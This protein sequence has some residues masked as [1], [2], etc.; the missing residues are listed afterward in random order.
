MTYDPKETEKKWQDFW[1]RE[2]IYRFDF[3]SQKEV[4]S[5][6]NPPRY[7]SGALHLGHA[8]H[9]THI[10]FIARYKRMRGYNVF[11]PLCY[12]VNGMPI[13]V[14]VEKLHN[15]RMRDLPR[16]EFVKLCED[17]A[18][19]KIDIMTEQF[20][21]LGESMDPSIYYQTDA[22][23]YRKITQLTFLDMVEKGLVYRALHPVNWCPR[24][25]TAIAESEVVYDTR[26]TSLYYID[27]DLEDG[28][29]VTI[30]TT[31]P[32]LI[33]ACLFLSYN[34]NDERYKNLEGKN[35][36]I[37]LFKRKVPIYGL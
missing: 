13:E 16:Q 8:T 30:A 28:G 24:C 32:E 15:V 22:P 5:I 29:K 4:F 1:E 2:K 10:D 11:F 31:R 26:K 21:I 12:D 7:A 36:I 17:F 33:P 6:D 18:K 25:G 3:S 19:S 20:K 34:K 35:V 23:Y 37:P 9:Y 14:N 27:F